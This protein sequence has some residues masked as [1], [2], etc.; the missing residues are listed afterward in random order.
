VTHS[1][2]LPTIAST[3]RL[4]AVLG[5]LAFGLGACSSATG[6]DSTDIACSPTAT[7]TYLN[8]GQAFMTTNCAACHGPGSRT[9][10]TSLA[11]IRA[12]SAAI[13]DATVYNITMP[14]NADLTDAQRIELG[15]W[16][17]CGAP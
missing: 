9:D 2:P 16:L 5:A 6:F 1:S 13:I 3:A 10:V 15:K 11:A 14:Q 17:T 8:F 12:N 4:F 7:D